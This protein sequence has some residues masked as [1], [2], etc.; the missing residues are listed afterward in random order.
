M[1]GDLA[2]SFLGPPGS[3]GRKK[4]SRVFVQRAVER[5]GLCV[6]RSREPGTVLEPPRLPPETLHTDT[7]AL[8]TQ[9]GVTFSPGTAQL[10]QHPALSH[11][12]L[13]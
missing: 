12:V 2:S 13:L 9:D 8:C 5:E 11:S 10:G 7:S 1:G 3:T 6:R 4:K